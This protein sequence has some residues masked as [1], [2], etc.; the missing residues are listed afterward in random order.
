MTVWFCSIWKTL[1]F[2]SS[3]SLH[4]GRYDEGGAPRTVLHVDFVHPEGMKSGESDAAVGGGVGGGGLSRGG[5]SHVLLEA[6][7]SAVSH[8]PTSHQRLDMH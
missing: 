6:I 3:L 8:V 4:R 7:E 1:V 5:V 2:F